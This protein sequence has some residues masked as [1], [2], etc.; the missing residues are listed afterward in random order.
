MK[1]NK[2]ECNWLTYGNLATIHYNAGLHDN[3]RTV[4][5][6]PEKFE[7]LR[8]CEAF[9]TIINLYQRMSDLSRFNRAWESLKSVFCTPSNIS[10]LLVLSAISDLGDLECLER[11]F[12][13]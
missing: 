3:A 5:E 10:Y 9:H 6:K 1:R 13:E 2:V 4:L 7:N 12:R 11:C 8:Y